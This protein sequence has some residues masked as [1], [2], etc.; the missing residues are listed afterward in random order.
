[1]TEPDHSQGVISFW[2]LAHAEMNTLAV[3]ETGTN[4]SRMTLWS[5]H[6][7]CP[8]CAAAC[9]FTGVGNVIFIAPDPSDDDLGEDPDAIATESVIVANLLF[10]SGV[11]A[12][13]GASS[14]MIMRAGQREPEITTLMRAIGDTALRRPALRGAL[15]PAWPAI[16]AAARERRTRV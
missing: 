14:S 15:A 13:R 10:L 3:I 8:M 7:P 9:E 2:Q 16:Q 1:M 12:Y 6:R 11:A 5:S 4:L